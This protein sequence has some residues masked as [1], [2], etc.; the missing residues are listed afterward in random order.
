MGITC[1]TRL[2]FKPGQYYSIKGI[3]LKSSFRYC[4]M[5]ESSLFYHET[6][7]AVW[8]VYTGIKELLLWVHLIKREQDADAETHEWKVEENG[9][10]R[11]EKREPEI[12]LYSC[13]VGSYSVFSWTL[14]SPM[15]TA[16]KML[17]VIGRIK[18]A[19]IPACISNR[20]GTMALGVI[21]LMSYR[22]LSKEHTYFT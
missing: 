9:T 5:Q 15:A 4:T 16:R 12:S 13:F 17:P 21:E 2:Q 19:P 6:V 1:I 3:W 14:A 8:F 18:K 22:G 20:H 10:K 11:K 7:A